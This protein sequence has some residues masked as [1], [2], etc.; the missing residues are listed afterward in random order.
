[1]S[2]GAQEAEFIVRFALQGMTYV[3]KFAGEAGKN[4]AAMI[5]AIAKQPDNSPGKKSLKDML[6]SRETLYNFTIKEE[7]LDD[8]KKEAKRYGIQYCITKRNKQDQNYIDGVY[9]ILLKQSDAPRINRIIEKLNM[10]VVDGHIETDV[11]EKEAEK[12]VELS[13]AQKTINDMMSPN[14]AERREEEMK[15]EG[16]DAPGVEPVE[17]Q[18]AGYYSSSDDRVSVKSSLQ[19]AKTESESVKDIFAEARMVREGMM[20]DA[21][22]WEKPEVSSDEEGKTVYR[23]KSFDE[24][25]DLDTMQYYA[26]SEMMQNGK[27]SDE[28][29]NQMFEKGYR[30]NKKGIIEKADIAISSREREII[31]L[32]MSDAKELGNDLSKIKEAVNDVR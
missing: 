19:E 2:E 20:S 32:M 16:M 29:I 18:S 31:S 22:G 15:K 10:A 13:E 21:P 17:T 7:Q 12:A 8:F 24:F 28:F 6:K 14:Q 30:I 25:T 26:D 3:L 5:M 27:L 11:P 9:D 4:M 23:G 1:M